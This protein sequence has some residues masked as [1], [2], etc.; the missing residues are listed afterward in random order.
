MNNSSHTASEKRKMHLSDETLEGI[1][2]SGMTLYKTNRVCYSEVND[3]VYRHFLL[4]PYVVLYL[5]V[6]VHTPNFSP[7][8]TRFILLQ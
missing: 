1:R 3:C 6:H 7:S 4:S 5:Q 2:I 8:P